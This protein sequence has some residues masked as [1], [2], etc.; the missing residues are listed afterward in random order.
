MRL[1]K[2]LTKLFF[3]ILLTVL[4][5]VNLSS[6]ALATDETNSAFA[7]GSGTAKDPYLIGTKEHLDNVRN[8][9]TACFSMICDIEFTD[10]DFAE[11]GDFYNDGMGWIP[12]GGEDEISFSGMF[13]GKGFA[14][15]GLQ[16]NTVDYMDSTTGL[17]KENLGEIV[18]LALVDGSIINTT[19]NYSSAGSFAGIN[20]GVISGCYSTMD[21]LTGNGGGIAAKNY[22]EIVD[23]YNMGNVISKNET[24]NEC[25]GIAAVNY[26]DGTISSCYNIGN[27]FADYEGG[28]AGRNSGQITDCYYL[29]NELVGI[30]EKGN[31]GRKLSLS[32][33]GLENSFAGFDFSSVWEMHTDSEISFPVLKGLR[34]IS[35]S[36][37]ENTTDFAGGTGSLLNPFLISTVEQL[38]KIDDYS[39]A[40]FKLACDIA[41]TDEEA[42]NFVSIGNYP[43]RFV[44]HFDGNGYAI[45]GLTKSLFYNNKGT[46]KNLSVTNGVVTDTATVVCNNFGIVSGCYSSSDISYSSDKKT[47]VGGLVGENRGTVTN[48]FYT[49]NVNAKASYP[50]SYIGGLVGANE[51]G[52]IS[53]CYSTGTAPVTE[54]AGG[55]CGLNNGKIIYSYCYEITPT[56]VADG[57]SGGSRLTASQLTSKIVFDDYD[58]ES[59]WAIDTT[60]NY[61]APTLKVMRTKPIIETESGNDFDGG[62]GNAFYPYLIS[63]AEQFKNISLYSTSRKYFK[64]TGDV[65]LTGEITDNLITEFNGILEGNSFSVAGLTI[66]SGGSDKNVG[67]IGENS[68]IIRNLTLKNASITL[69]DIS[70]SVVGTLVGINS[71]TIQ[72]IN[73]QTNLYGV[74]LTQAKKINIGGI[75]GYSYTPIKNCSTF[76][77]MDLDLL[78]GAN[79]LHVGGVVGSVDASV[80]N[81]TNKIDITIDIKNTTRGSSDLM[82]GGIVG[83]AYTSQQKSLRNEGAITVN[84][85]FSGSCI[86]RYYV[87]GISG[88]LQG[89]SINS[90]SNIADVII[91]ETNGET[92][93]YAFAG[94]ILGQ[95]VDGGSVSLSY[96]TAD[97]IVHSTFGFIYAGGV[98][99]ETSS[100]ITECY[101]AGHVGSTTDLPDS[102]IPAAGG[103][104]GYGRSG[105]KVARCYN[106][107]K[108]T[109]PRSGGITGYNDGVR[110]ENVYYINTT[111]SG[112]GYG[113]S[114]NTIPCSAEQLV[115]KSYLTALNFSSN[116]TIG[117]VSGYNYPTLRAVAHTVTEHTC[118]AG[119]FC[120]FN[121]DCH[122]TR[123]DACGAKLTEAQHSFDYDCD[124]KCVSCDYTREAEHLKNG[125]WE[126]DQHNHW[127]ICL[128]CNKSIKIS[129][130]EYASGES[131]SCGVCSAERYLTSIE[132][133]KTATKTEYSKGEALDLSDM[134]VTAYY[135]NGTSAEI[136]GYTVSGDTSVIGNTTINISF[137]G[138]TAFFEITVVCSGHTYSDYTYN[139]DGLCG[140]NGTET[141]YCDNGCGISDTRTK[142]GS[143]LTHVSDSGSITKGAT[144]TSVG[145]KIYKCTLCQEEIKSET[146]PK[147]A[148]NYDS[149]KVTKKATCKST[150]VKT[151]TCSKCS[152]TK[153]ETI[154]KLKTHTY[155]NSCDKSCNVCKATRTIK[156]TYSNACDSSCN[157]CKVTRSISHSYKTTTTKATLSKNGSVVKKCSV[158]GKT[159]TDTVRYV[160][161]I[162]LSTKTYTYNGKVKKPSVVVKDS[163][164][165]ILKLNTDYTITYSSGRKNV[166]TYKV[167]IKLIGKYSG[168]KTL[169]FK[170]NPSETSVS[171]L[172]AGKK[173]VTVS[174]KKNT[175]QVSG[176]QIRYSTSKT[177]SNSTIKT[178]SGSNTTKCTLKGLKTGRTYYV[179]VRTYKTVAGVRYYSGWSTYK[180]VK[181]K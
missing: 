136:Y 53:Y 168:T 16:C 11:G 167:T 55:V 62:C 117:A 54:N 122:W 59:V 83:C 66:R 130:H 100:S 50:G 156:H 135:D 91:S 65:E 6:L 63:T 138:K 81:V 92:S 109:S 177:F 45:S 58:F 94:G 12:I 85:N 56:T 26:K 107:G 34:H 8:Y 14:I 82:C 108:V 70:E 175:T 180:Y 152:G 68:G 52:T 128:L 141:A 47:I 172:T 77:Q 57:T 64:L 150:G 84:G 179:S 80:T 105:G 163:A 93:S 170:I 112:V 118:V 139:N 97:V 69:S 20:N 22:G 73:A 116:W 76:G 9:P 18:N 67:L 21:I 114:D 166:G 134:I 86:C 32:E 33:L 49:G 27:V 43:T 181:T 159:V 110:H 98:V 160:K 35:P 25:G 10:S 102:I 5:A 40:C 178:I 61:P 154:S 174:V 137:S 13:D 133:T 169:T 171:K 157:I 131:F 115:D 129:E 75:A 113:K 19:L 142:E 145:T 176:Y 125:I 2:T 15:I 78:A 41:F 111:E 126:K 23:C 99:G 46:I 158:C 71:G 17:F 155:T 95:S 74:N 24:I 39:Y 140:V 101:N 28:I 3:I 1:C 132:I 121:G 151:Y 165:N 60:A 106:A 123:C 37:E 90:S 144:C 36:G 119:E 79:Y 148:H 127:Q 31:A 72:N 164:G 149:C 38:S 161:S 29:E 48:C 87:G 173:S 4:F 162:S 146:L 88:K 103:I 7:G 120:Y 147:L 143:A 104:L 44:G 124:K 51:E 96:N 30:G 153:T 89:G 42:E